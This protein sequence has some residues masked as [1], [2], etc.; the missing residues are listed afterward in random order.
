MQKYKFKLLRTTTVGMSLNVLLKGQFRFFQE[1]G[2]E[3]TCVSSDSPELIAVGLR[4][5]VKIRAVKMTRKIS[6]FY[7]LISFLRMYRLILENRPDIVHSHTPKAGIVTML[8]AKL[9]GVPVRF[10]TVAGLPLMETNGLKRLLL[11]YVEYITY[12]CSTK[13]L[14]NSFGLQDFIIKEGL[15]ARAKTKVIGNGSS[16]GIDTD[17]FSV[18][19]I[20][21]TTINSL[22]LKLGI[23]ESDFVFIFVGRLVKDK[24]VNELVEAFLRVIESA[25]YN[26]RHNLKLLLVGPFEMELDPLSDKTLR[27]INENKSILLTGYVSDVRSYY[28][29]GDCLVFPSY[30]EG[31]PNVV[32]QAGAMGLPAIVSDINGCNEIITDGLNGFVIPSKNVNALVLAMKRISFQY[33]LKTELGLMARGMIKEQYD[34]NK[35][36]SLQK[37]EYLNHLM[38]KNKN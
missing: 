38:S 20:S 28:A 33:K 30:R 11:K 1:N 24:G 14:P 6:P 19:A 36:W 12:L 3:V 21:S 17:F 37:S 26:V 34:Q 27:C 2:F 15:V 4:E 8:A 18:S 22:K 29:I 10:H 5:G 9:A 7:D 13:V 16:N 25:D 31:F 32:L 23:C 35:F